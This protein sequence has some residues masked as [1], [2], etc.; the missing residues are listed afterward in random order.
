VPLKIELLSPGNYPLAPTVRISF[1]VISVICL[2][3]SVAVLY[4]LTI[5]GFGSTAWEL[6]G[7]QRA[8]YAPSREL[9]PLNAEHLNEIK[10]LWLQIVGVVACAVAFLRPESRAARLRHLPFYVIGFPSLT[11]LVFGV[12]AL[13]HWLFWK[14]GM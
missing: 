2:L 3:M 9:D 11:A 4:R 10:L 7:S 8:P 5:L 1:G 12:T 6:L 13:L 14:R